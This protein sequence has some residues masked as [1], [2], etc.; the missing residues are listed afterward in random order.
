MNVQARQGLPFRVDRN[1]LAA[2]RQRAF[3]RAATAIALGAVRKADPTSILRT[4]WPNDDRAGA[5]LKAV[6]GPIDTTT[7]ALGLDAVTVLPA[8]A[9][10]SA[11]MK[12]FQLGTK[13]DLRGKHSISVPNIAVPPGPI[14]IAEDA[15]A[16]A[17]EFPF[18]KT[19]V[20]PVRTIRLHSAISR[21]LEQASPESAVLIVSRILGDAAAKGIDLVAFSTGADDGT[22]PAGLLHGVT[23]LTAAPAGTD[24]LME[25]VASLTAAIAAAF[26][27]PDGVVFIAAPRQAM[28]LRIK[29]S[30]LFDSPV[31]LAAALPDKTVIAAAP[32]GIYFGYDGGAEVDSSREALIHFEDTT[33]LP[34]L[35]PGTRS[36]FQ[37]DVIFLRCRAR[38]AWCA[39]P[40]AIQIVQGVNW[41]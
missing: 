38:A 26:I 41:P 28:A 22:K 24:S 39:Y 35:A 7:T 32:G 23:P 33:P 20:G 37:T 5:V 21:E 10:S 11:A 19:A 40:G 4:E 14:F 17:V 31:I 6:S 12:L 15:P 27:D 9:P 25:D 2:E 8:L 13:L 16:P 36:A 29:P 3:A 18:G 34:L 30:P 1:A